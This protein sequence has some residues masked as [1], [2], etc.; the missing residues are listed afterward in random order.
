MASMMGGRAAI[1]KPHDDMTGDFVFSARPGDHE[2]AQVICEA[3]IAAVTGQ[4]F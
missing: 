3:A 4:A 1:V 2:L